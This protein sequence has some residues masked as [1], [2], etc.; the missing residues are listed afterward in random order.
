MSTRS[1]SEPDVLVDGR[2]LGLSLLASICAAGGVGVVS[3]YV[4]NRTMGSA[5]GWALPQIVTFAVYGTLAAVLCYSFRPPSRPPIALRFTG[6]KY[7]AFA[8]GATVVLMAAC[9]LAYAVL[10]LFFGG[11]LQLFQQLTAVATDAKRLQGQA[12]SAWVVTILRGCL[13]VPIFEEVFFRGLLLS[14]LNRH[15]RFAFALLVMAVLF[16]AMHIYAVALPYTFL[17]AIATGYVRR[18]TGSTANTVLMHVI[19]NIVLLML[20]SHFFGH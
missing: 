16:A 1:F 10:G 8:V 7:L 14:W 11:F 4:L 9:A 2:R 15:M 19:N 6:I 20:G 17:F 12:S 13:L 3:Y 5:L 18:R